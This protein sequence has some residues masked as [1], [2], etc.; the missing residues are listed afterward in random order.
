MLCTGTADGKFWA[1]VRKQQ[2]VNGTK[3]GGQRRLGC[4][5]ACSEDAATSPTH[6]SHT[7][8]TGQRSLGPFAGLAGLAGGPRW[9]SPGMHAAQCFIFLGTSYTVPFLARPHSSAFHSAAST[10][11]R[12]L[13][14]VDGALLS[15]LLLWGSPGRI[16][17]LCPFASSISSTS[18]S[19]D[20]PPPPRRA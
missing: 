4:L 2:P 3:R 15:A 12:S 20:C 1:L 10:C 6:A 16:D 11:I 14:R 8:N 7:E 9:P 13:W 18:S 5:L 17:V 19:S